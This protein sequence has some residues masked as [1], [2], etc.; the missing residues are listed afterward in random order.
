MLLR[1]PKPELWLFSGLCFDFPSYDLLAVMY[2]DICRIIDDVT[3]RAG[4]LDRQHWVVL[5]V[6][7]LGLGLIMMRG[8]GSR[9][10]Y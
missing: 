10:N 4:H 8:F 2:Q 1:L 9:T 6:L 3:R 7:I 5:S